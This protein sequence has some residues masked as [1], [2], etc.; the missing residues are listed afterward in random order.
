MKA[1]RNSYP[2]YLFLYWFYFMSTALFTTLISVYLIGRQYSASQ[3]SNLVST[4]FFLS[5]LAQPLFGYI[6]ERFGIVKI[7]TLSLVVLMA[8]VGGF[9]WAPNYFWLTIFYGLVLLCLNGTAPMME[10][11]ATQSPYAFGKIR[12][13]G[14]LGYAAGAQLAGWLYAHLSPQSVYY[15]VLVTLLLSFFTLGAIRIDKT[16]RV[17]KEAVSIR[18]LLHN[19]PYLF[20]LLLMGIVSEIGRAHV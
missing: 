7:T 5:M 9:I 19:G 8:G 20:F 12:V 14:T 4:A 16:N 13:W 3:V 17:Q 18:P 15:C 2:A 6:N 1:F 11:F 10:V